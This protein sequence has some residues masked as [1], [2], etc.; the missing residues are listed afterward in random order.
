M[1]KEILKQIVKGIMLCE[2]EGNTPFEKWM[3][4]RNLMKNCIYENE[5][6]DV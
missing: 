5:I 6:V 4:A 3:N 1:E 2:I